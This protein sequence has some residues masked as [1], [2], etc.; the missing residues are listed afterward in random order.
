[1]S[2]PSLPLWSVSYVLKFCCSQGHAAAS[3]VS[4]LPSL[5]LSSR[6]NPWSCALTGIATKAPAANAALI[7]YLRSMTF[8]A[9]LKLLSPKEMCG[10]ETPD[11]GLLDGSVPCVDRQDRHV[12]NEIVQRVLD[13]KSRHVVTSREL[14]HSLR[15][16]S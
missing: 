2:L 6:V 11:L 3:V 4:M 13:D 14:L 16:T 15:H 5:F 9:G 8:L 10:R 12:P 7:T 1:S